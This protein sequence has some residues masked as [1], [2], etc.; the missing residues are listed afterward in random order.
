MSAPS[1]PEKYS[2]DEMMER[3][4][5]P[6]PEG[7]VEDGELVTRADGSQA[8]RV[9][10]RKR[11][12]QQPHKEQRQHWRRTRMVQVSSVLILLLLGIFIAGVTIVFVNS[13][14]F[15]EKILRQIATSSGASVELE[16][17]RMNPTCANADRLSLVWP[18][19]NALQSLT[20]STIKAD[21]SLASFFGQ[22]LGGEEVS[23]AEGSL[24]LRIPQL[25]QPTR[26]P[27]ADTG[28]PS[29]HFSR[30]AVPKAQV[31]LGNPKAPWILLQNSEVSFSP[32][33]VN[34]RVQLLLSGGDLTIQSWPKLRMDRAHIEFRDS[35]VDIVGMRLRHA[36]DL[37]GVFEI[38]GTVAPY[39]AQ[40][41]STLALRLESYLL[42][43]IIGPEL[44][45]LISGRIDTVADA[46]SNELTFS[47]DLEPNASLAITFRNSPTS[48]V[49]LD[50][51]PFLFGLS[52]T[53]GDE[54]FERPI[55]ESEAGG[56]LLRTNGK[57]TL[58]KLNLE[59]KGRMALR[60]S[61][62]MAA[63][64]KLSGDLEVGIAAAMIK[65]SKSRILDALFGPPSQGFRWLT[66][67]IGG[68]ATAPTDNFKTLF[69]ADQPAKSP[70]S[71]GEIPTFE[72][73]T[74][75]R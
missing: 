1:E 40:R 48:A 21:V 4:K 34:N 11:R 13:A 12:S 50:G 68:T 18:E 28:K 3:L 8:I 43:G 6:P 71:S 27:A 45:H 74:T 26:D 30:Y 61:L 67:T 17:F 24:N 19:G 53:L 2:I 59:T 33:N 35:E 54:W 41:A 37:R 20:L 39:T 25:D 44:G 57:V 58:R 15:R 62:T 66:L 75:P 70:I 16:K 32:V 49:E 47:P 60:G 51:F 22:S 29:I 64:Q 38:S 46:K 5:S 7:L 9:R 14:P 73:L 10:K 69:Q 55:F 63:D 42:A 72:E 65:S 23:A 36:T 56:T 31:L 52:Q